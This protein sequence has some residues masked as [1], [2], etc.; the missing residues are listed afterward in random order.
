M[1]NCLKFKTMITMSQP[2]TVISLE[3]ILI[4]FLIELQNFT[5]S[6][7][8]TRSYFRV[9]PSCQQECKGVQSHKQNVSHMYEATITR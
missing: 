6:K 1:R 7:S 5:T 8:K 3:N 4:Y 2:F 9:V